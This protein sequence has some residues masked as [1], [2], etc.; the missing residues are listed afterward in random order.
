MQLLQRNPS[1][2]GK[3]DYEKNEV[4]NETDLNANQ[5]PKP[6]ND[7]QTKTSL[8]AE[9][10]D[11]STSSHITEPVNF[12]NNC[13]QKPDDQDMELPPPIHEPSF[14]YELRVLYLS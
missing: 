6:S 2:T 14:I 10:S 11:T 7:H 5:P 12:C 4:N 3:H 13:H 9:A 1:E 8:D